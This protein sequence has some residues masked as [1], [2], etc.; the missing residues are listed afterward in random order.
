MLHCQ[1]SRLSRADCISRDAWLEQGNGLRKWVS[2][3]QH[4][5]KR[6]EKTQEGESGTEST[7]TVRQGPGTEDLGVEDE[8]SSEVSAGISTDGG[9]SARDD[10]SLQPSSEA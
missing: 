5:K 8:L 7:N 1:A 6:E 10:Q 3:L 9:G 4:E 2:T